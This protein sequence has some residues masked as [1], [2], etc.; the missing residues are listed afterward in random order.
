M[1]SLYPGNKL[2]SDG[3]FKAMTQEERD[4]HIHKLLGC[5]PTLISAIFRTKNYEMI[6]T[7]DSRLG[8]ISNLLI[9]TLGKENPYSKNPKIIRAMELLFIITADKGI[10]CT[11]A[12]IRHMASAMTDIYSTI[13]VSISALQSDSQVGSCEQILQMFTEISSVENVSEFM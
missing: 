12:S 1:S 10:D 13:N 11:S 5:L 9:M 3:Q 2:P 8:Y 7:P 6:Q 4:C